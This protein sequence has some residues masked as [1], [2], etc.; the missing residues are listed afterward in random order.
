MAKTSGHADLTT[1]QLKV[2]LREKNL[3]VAF[4]SDTGSPEL[5]YFNLPIS[6]LAQYLIS[7]IN[8]IP[9]QGRSLVVSLLPGNSPLAVRFSIRPQQF[10]ILFLIQCNI[11]NQ[12]GRAALFTNTAEKTQHVIHRDT[13]LTLFNS[14]L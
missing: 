4:C 11:K 7:E 8:L 6:S 9:L 14:A 1:K 3:V 13:E 10:N 5:G 12:C 2:V